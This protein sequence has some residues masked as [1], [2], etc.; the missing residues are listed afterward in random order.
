MS[1]AHFINNIFGERGTE[2]Q[3]VIDL[4]SNAGKLITGATLISKKILKVA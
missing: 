2:W 1:Q 4:F 3:S